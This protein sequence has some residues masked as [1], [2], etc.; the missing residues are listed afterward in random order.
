MGEHSASCVAVHHKLRQMVSL[1]AALD[2]KFKFDVTLLLTSR[3]KYY[4]L[5]SELVVQDFHT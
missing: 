4:S 3:L 2:G 1:S 5:S